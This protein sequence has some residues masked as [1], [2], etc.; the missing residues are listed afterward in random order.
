[1]VRRLGLAFVLSAAVVA[2]LPL[3][4]QVVIEQVLVNVNGDIVTLSEFE[5]RQVDILRDRPEL[6]RVSAN[7]PQFLKAMADITPPLILAAVDELLW[8]QRAREHGWSLTPSRLDDM[9]QNIRKGQ[10]LED[11]AAFRRAL[12][13]EG[14]TEETLRQRF[15]R[16]ALIQ[17]AQQV[18]VYEK[19][20][21]GDEEIRTYYDT[22]LQRFTKPSDITIREILIAPG[23][24]E[25]DVAEAAARAR[26]EAARARLVAGEPFPELVAELSS[27]PTKANGGL[28]G[29][30]KLEELDPALQAAFAPLAVGQ[31]T[32][33][34]ATT[35]GSQIFK[36]ESKTEAVAQPLSE[37]RGE[38]SRR[39]ADQKSQGEMVKY[40]EK[41]RS[42]AK[43]TWRH[44]E[45]KK[46]YEH[47]LTQ[48]LER[49]G[50]GVAPPKKG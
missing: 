45:L 40:L 39:L 49:A 46:A 34:M 37:V 6:A 35:R 44:D 50:L 10:G 18:D 29:P 25:K 30:L 41:L 19:I 8:V 5:D 24:G 9:I 43:I 7:S 38:I 33:V 31:I 2:S 14:L 15:E 23:P 27:S 11:D 22:N 1:M 26:A 13:A 3:G 4:A 12:Q 17:Q 47:A 16:S 36:L 48:R 28:I 42:Q 32:P 20:E 21:I